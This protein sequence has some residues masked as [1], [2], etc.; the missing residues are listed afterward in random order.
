MITLPGT[1]VEIGTAGASLVSGLIG[2]G[3]GALASILATVIANRSNSRIARESRQMEL[4]KQ[5]NL[6]STI[7]CIFR[8]L[9]RM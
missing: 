9:P 1:S 4:R 7:C 6:N 5:G 2:A 8:L 3:I